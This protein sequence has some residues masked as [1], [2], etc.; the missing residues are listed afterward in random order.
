MQRIHL[1]Y[2]S[3]TPLLPEVRQAMVAALEEAGNPSSIH[4]SGRRA[5]QLLEQ[6]R[7]QV[8]S[9]I[10][11]KPDEIYFT[12]CGTESNNWALRGLMTANKRKGNHLIVCAIEH[13][14]VLLSARRLEGE[15]IQ[16]SIL[17]VDRRGLVSVDDL[18][19]TL[20]PETVLV[21]L[22]LANGEVGTL[23]PIQ[24]L[25]AVAHEQGT[26]FHTD[27]IAAVGNIPVDVQALG[28]DALSLSANLFYGPSGAAALFVREGVRILA[29]LEGGGQEGGTRSGTEGLIAI[30]GMGVAAAEARQELPQRM[31]RLKTLRDTLRDALLARIESIRLNG[32]WDARLPHNVHL[33]VDS[34][35]SESLVLGLDQAGIAVGLGSACNSKSMRPSH[36]LKAMGLT[37]AQAQGALMLT[38]GILTN[39]DE[40]AQAALVIREVVKKLRRV[41]QLTARPSL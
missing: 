23:E 13:P 36:V 8:A 10:N 35:S 19:A 2:A 31:S 39:E 28:V 9:L 14:S 1:D 40:I 18:K 22:M 27:A 38:V 7:S 21:S 33:C 24:E 30:V 25:A 32:S 12:S 20:R 29:F 26:L 37:D 17:P 41:V 15:G 6:A 5:K 4:T 34:L 3:T 16:V 11:A